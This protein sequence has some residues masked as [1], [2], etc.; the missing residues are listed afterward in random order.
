[1]FD[2]TLDF[3]ANNLNKDVIAHDHASEFPADSWSLCA[4]HG[5]HGW[6]MPEQQGGKAHSTLI[7][8]QLFEAMGQ[9]CTDNGLTFALGAQVWSVQMPLLHFGS[10]EQINRYLPEMISGRSIG[11]FAITE[12]GSGSDAFALATSASKEGDHYVLNG[13]KVMITLAP[14]SSVAIVFAVTNASAKQWGISAFLIDTDTP[15]CTLSANIPK[16]GL[17]SVPFGSITFDN[18]RI[19]ASTLLGSE[20]AGSAIFNYSQSLE[21]CL[22]LAPQVG[23]MQRLLDLSVQF[24]K[25]RTRSGES[26]GKHQAVAHRISNMRIGLETSRLLLYKNAWLIDQGNANLMEAAIAKTQISEA[27]VSCCHDA[28]A[29]HGGAGYLTENELERQARDALG[30]TIYGGTVDIQRNIIAGLLGL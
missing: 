26:I 7:A 20:G 9:G 27:F 28:I 18:C 4:E 16:M 11:S 3:A 13:E 14:V 22:V 30:A 17:R 29:I 6:T 15:G 12:H 8:C 21:R 1:M 5:V 24:A 2:S 10:P 23:A 25:R 19:P